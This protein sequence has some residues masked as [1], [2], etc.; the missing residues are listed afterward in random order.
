MVASGVYL[1]APR[2]RFG[3]L[4]QGKLNIS[5]IFGASELYGIAGQTFR[6]HQNFVRLSCK[7]H[8]TLVRVKKKYALSLMYYSGVEMPP[9]L[10]HSRPK[11]Y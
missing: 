2:A 8:K 11:A 7:C 9:V 3:L 10:A 4:Q 5:V 6:L 1:A